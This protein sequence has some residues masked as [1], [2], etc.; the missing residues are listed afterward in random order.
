MGVMKA[1]GK[2]GARYRKW[3]SRRNQG[4]SEAKQQ[5]QKVKSQIRIFDNYL[6]LEEKYIFLAER[7]QLEQ[8][9]QG[10]CLWGSRFHSL[11]ADP[12]HVWAPSWWFL[13]LVC[14]WRSPC[15][16]LLLLCLVLPRRTP[17]QSL[18]L[19]SLCPSGGWLGTEIRS[20]STS[21]FALSGSAN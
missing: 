18:A 14:L 15:C 10:Q 21:S 5:Q 1:H 8:V 19:S 20:F 7:V 17:E 12:S 16:S 2:E 11:W 3:I 9:A 6:H 13:L 4:W